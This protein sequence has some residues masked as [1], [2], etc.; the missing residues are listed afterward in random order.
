MASHCRT[1]L[2]SER[3]SIRRGE[4]GYA[5]LLRVDRKFFASS[6]P[7]AASCFSGGGQ[8]PI[9]DGAVDEAGILLERPAATPDE[10]NCT[11]Q[12]ARRG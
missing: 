3:S 10:H 2:C 12:A 7:W 11:A 9:G 8:Q 4:D 1:G 5:K 6:D